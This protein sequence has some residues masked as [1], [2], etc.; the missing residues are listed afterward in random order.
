MV[1]SLQPGVASPVLVS[2]ILTRK[3]NSPITDLKGGIKIVKNSPIT[4]YF[5]RAIFQDSP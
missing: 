1:R 3:N 2:T 4:Y 5:V